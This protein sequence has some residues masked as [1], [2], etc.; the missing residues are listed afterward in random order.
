MQRATILTSIPL[1]IIAGQQIYHY[2]LISESATTSGENEASF[3][4]TFWSLYFLVN[5]II[6][7]DW[8]LYDGKLIRLSRK[9]GQIDD[10]DDNDRDNNNDKEEL[11]SVS[12]VL[13]IQ[14][15][16]ILFTFFLSFIRRFFDEGGS[17]R[18]S[19][20]MKWDFTRA[21]CAILEV[22]NVIAIV[23]EKEIEKYF[24]KVLKQ[25]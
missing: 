14:K 6:A 24:I 15:V 10:D 8:S 17:T 3:A 22:I 18:T 12:Q 2:L 5:V 20:A 13:L 7:L 4:L 11:I 25:E 19:N 16:A 23:A 1:S 9:R 21:S